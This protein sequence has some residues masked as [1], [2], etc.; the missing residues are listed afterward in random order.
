MN[1]IILTVEAN[2][3]SLTREYALEAILDDR[4]D[5]HMAAT[6]MLKAIMESN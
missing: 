1:K 3:H 6:D 5:L 2:G 4:T